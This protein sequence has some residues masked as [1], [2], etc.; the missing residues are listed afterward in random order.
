[1]SQP[2][3][4][5][6]HAADRKLSIHTPGHGSYLTYIRNFVGDLAR[7]VGFPEE[8]I[9]KIEMSVDEACSNVVKHAYA[10][11]KKWLWQHRHPEIRLD[12]QVQANQIIIEIH[13]HGQQFDFAAYRP[14]AIPERLKDM[15]T[16]GYGISIMREFMD[17]VTYSSSD[18]TGNTL[19]LVKYLKKT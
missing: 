17:E 10:P 2:A 18:A 6:G 9:A 3:H 15:K 4:D 5:A 19:R 1:M 11:K 12:L 16:N 13:D 14:D 8:D 7:Q